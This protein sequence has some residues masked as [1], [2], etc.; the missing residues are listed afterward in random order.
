[1]YLLGG[2]VPFETLLF[3]IAIVD[4][5]GGL[6]LIFDWVSAFHTLLFYFGVIMLVKGLWSVFDC[7]RKKFYFDFLGWIDVVSGATM[8]LIFFGWS[9][10]FL[11]FLGIIILIKGL[12]SM[13]NAV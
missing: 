7:I 12:W 1:M 11:W 2:I 5:I 13:L 9:L 4:V 6:L 3:T 10:S 8:L